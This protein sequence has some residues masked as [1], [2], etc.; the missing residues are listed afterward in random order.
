MAFSRGKSRARD[1]VAEQLHGEQVDQRTQAHIGPAGAGGRLGS[2]LLHLVFAPQMLQVKADIRSIVTR[3]GGG[4]VV[5][6]V[7][8]LTG[9]WG[10]P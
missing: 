3:G 6:V 10:G 7:G 4:A 2:E 1:A 8:W 9:A 5:S